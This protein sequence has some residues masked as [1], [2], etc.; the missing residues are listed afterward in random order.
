MEQSA[1]AVYLRAQMKQRG[2]KQNRL[3]AEA[4]ISTS[5]LSKLLHEPDREPELS[6]LMRL[7]AAL[8]VPVR[9][10]LE[11]AGVEIEPPTTPD[12]RQRRISHLLE[13]APWF[14]QASEYLL[15]MSE[16]DQEA[17]LV[18]LE[19]LAERNQKAQR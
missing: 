14:A 16:A 10:L 3:A 8:K 13:V 15:A 19:M 6:T 5:A 2:W 18:Y 12:D 11:V 1:L 9:T 4:D 17:A 7:S